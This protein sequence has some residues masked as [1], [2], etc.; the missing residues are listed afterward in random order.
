[1]TTEDHRLTDAQITIAR[2]ETEIAHLQRSVTALSDKLDSIQDMLA[3]A[4]G[5]WRA[6]MWIGGAAASIGAAASWI[7]QHVSWGGP[8]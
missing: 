2:L 4:R 5:G 1:M 3:E 6:M 7:A 8:P